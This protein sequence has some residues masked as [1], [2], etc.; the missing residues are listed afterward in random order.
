MAGRRCRMS[1][2]GLLAHPTSGLRRAPSPSTGS[3]SSSRSGRPV[4]RSV[5]SIACSSVSMASRWFCRGRDVPAELELRVVVGDTTDPPGAAVAGLELGEVELPDLIRTRR[6]HHERR[7]SS[8][9]KLP[10]L[11]LVIDRQHSP[12]ALQRPEHSRVGSM[13]AVN[14]HQHRDLAVTPGQETI[15][16]LNSRRLNPVLLRVSLRTRHLTRDDR[17]NEPNSSS[18]EKTGGTRHI[19]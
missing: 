17:E 18:T 8:L 1:L 6:L 2:L 13:V 10:P 15:R 16:V 7:S 19:P 12:R 5:S 14:A 11:G 4:S 9:G 3:T